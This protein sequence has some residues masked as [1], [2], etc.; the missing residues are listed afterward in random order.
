MQLQSLFGV[1]EMDGYLTSSILALFIQLV[2][3]SSQGW[4][5]KNGGAIRH[6][7]HR[8]LRMPGIQIT[9]FPSTWNCRPHRLVHSPNPYSPYLFIYAY[10]TNPWNSRKDT[11]L[12][13]MKIQTRAPSPPAAAAAFWGFTKFHPQLSFSAKKNHYECLKLKLFRPPRGRAFWSTQCAKIPSK[14]H[15]SMLMNAC[16]QNKTMKKVSGIKQPPKHDRH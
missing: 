5:W 2:R 8:S 15:I 16:S 13:L 9:P 14:Q 11:N 4:R 3:Q 6:L 12:L 10:S 7:R 1:L